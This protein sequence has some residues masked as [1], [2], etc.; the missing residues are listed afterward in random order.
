MS[1]EKE[2]EE[3]LRGG[4]N[5]AGAVAGEGGGVTVAGGAQGAVPEGSW[6]RISRGLIEGMLVRYLSKD[7]GT[8]RYWTVK[9]LAG[10]SYE[11]WMGRTGR[12]KP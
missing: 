7:P 9:E 2:L 11:E 1:G 4:V 8:G 12:R 3:A 10:E 6:W 5:G